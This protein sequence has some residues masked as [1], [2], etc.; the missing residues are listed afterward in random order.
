MLDSE[1]K[2]LRE[3]DYTFRA[4]SIEELAAVALSGIL[5]RPLPNGMSHLKRKP[6]HYE[7]I[8]EAAVKSAEGL[9]KALEKRRGEV[10]GAEE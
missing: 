4:I 1:K 6:E 2:Q 8:G 10:N 5:A 9:L 7:L 3:F